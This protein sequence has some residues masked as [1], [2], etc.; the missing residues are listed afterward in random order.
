MTPESDRQSGCAGTG[1]A[2]VRLGVAASLPACFA[3]SMLA[4][5]VRMRENTGVDRTDCTTSLL[6][7]SP[8]LPPPSSP[9]SCCAATFVATARSGEAA[10]ATVIAAVVMQ[11]TGTG[12]ARQFCTSTSIG[13][14]NR[15]VGA[16]EPRALKPGAGGP[17]IETKDKQPAGDDRKVSISSSASSSIARP[18]SSSSVLVLRAMRSALTCRAAEN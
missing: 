18:R 6:L 8:P 3:R 17:I 4:K 2:L 10:A 11:V 14:V 13:G 15:V 5:D 1:A 7:L 12:A 9:K 16:P